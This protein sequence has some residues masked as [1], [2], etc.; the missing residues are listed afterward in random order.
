MESEKYRLKFEIEGLPQLINQLAWE[1][2]TKK[3]KHNDKWKHLVGLAVSGREPKE[4]LIKAKL[5]LTRCSSKRPDF[6]GLVSSWKSLID[7]LVLSKVII[8]DN[9]DVIGQSEF[10][11]ERVGP[12]EG[13]VRMEVIEL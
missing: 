7:G 11:W 3:K 4:P 13:K 2:W 9:Q 5:I 6:D 12:R 8:D 10:N 1:H